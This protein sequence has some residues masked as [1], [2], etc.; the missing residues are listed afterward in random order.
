M[1]WGVLGAADIAVKQ[2]VPAMRR[3]HLSR[4]VAI[5]SRDPAK[6]EAAARALHIPRAHG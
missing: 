4:V 1:R 6:A 3:S 5:A 2:V